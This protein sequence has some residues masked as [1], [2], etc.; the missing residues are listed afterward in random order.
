MAET[1]VRKKH[2]QVMRSDILPLGVSVS[3]DDLVVSIPTQEEVTGIEFYDKAAGKK[4]GSAKID[5]SY[6]TAG[7][8]SFRVK[9]A[10][11]FNYI[12]KGQGN[13]VLRDTYAMV[14]NCGADF[15]KPGT[16]SY[17]A[18][19]RDFDWGGER[20]PHYAYE[21]SFIYR[22]HVRGFTK[23]ISSKV[24]NRG[25]Y[26]GITEKTG[27]L[28]EL[29]VTAV[30][31]MPAY[32]FDEA[33]KD[34]LGIDRVN[35]WGYGNAHY[36][37][38]KESYSSRRDG[39]QVNEFKNMVKELH[40]AG[41]EVIMDFYFV[42][43]TNPY[44]ILDCLRHWTIEYHIDGFHVNMEVVPVEM[45]KKDPVLAD[46]KIF[47]DM[48]DAADRF[49]ERGSS[50]DKRLAILNDDFMVNVRRFIKS[51]EGQVYGLSEKLRRNP[52]NCG[53]INYLA[54]HYTFT[55]MDTVSYDRKHNED[56]GEGNKDGTDYNYSWNC[57]MEGPT[58]KKRIKTM[59]LKQIKNALTILFLSQGTPMLYTG[60]EM[61]RSQRGNNNPYCQDNDTMWLN[62]NL[63]KTNADIYEYVKRLVSFRREHT[64]LHMKNEPKNMDYLS[65]G[66][67]DMS[68]HGT[69]PWRTD[70]SYG[71]RQLGVMYNGRYGK[72]DEAG[73]YLV[74]NAYWEDIDFNI[75]EINPQGTSWRVAFSSDERYNAENTEI[76]RTIRLPARTVVVLEEIMNAPK[77]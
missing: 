63:L 61:G 43:D 21:N 41:I 77:K 26:S 73:V 28:K 10:A 76:S 11:R 38:P 44:L 34:G 12:I 5:D 16:L 45:I 49:G 51:D 20:R 75:P 30:E 55:L 32:E 62:W 1:T 25:T 52:A 2:F 18:Y 42:P 39:G 24:E 4:A 53:I 29:G 36:F 56:N 19:N 9:D 40:R 72:E 57:G 71:S 35:Y 47:A 67:P 69:D 58:R 65:K 66:L 60:D 50:K 23:H 48:W 59:R 74:C 37:A 17:S 68:Y 54:T 64:V 33:V 14:V 6:R 31:L 22:L 8:Y 15:G 27:Y 13:A 7:V 70:F 3:G 46:V